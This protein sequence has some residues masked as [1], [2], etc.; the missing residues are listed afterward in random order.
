MTELSQHFQDDKNTMEDVTQHLEENKPIKNEFIVANIATDDTLPFNDTKNQNNNC[1]MFSSS[2]EHSQSEDTLLQA[3]LEIQHTKLIE[4]QQQ[5]NN[6]EILM[7]EHPH[8]IRI[9]GIHVLKDNVWC[10]NLKDKVYQL[11]CDAKIP[12]FWI[13]DI[14]FNLDS[15]DP[16]LEYDPENP[17]D[18]NVIY[19]FDSTTP[20][21]VTLSNYFVKE[22]T[23]ELLNIFFDTEYDQL[24]QVF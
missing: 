20:V 6:M 4:L 1:F 18:E 16:S 17:T 7:R 24:M 19:S 9:M 21:Y 8:T 12:L 10:K 3:E 23:V 14:N 15:W 2:S 5:I 22:K 11:F 13:I